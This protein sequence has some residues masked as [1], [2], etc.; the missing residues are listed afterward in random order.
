MKKHFISNLVV[1]ALILSVALTS[2]SKDKNGK[3][4]RI[5]LS[6]AAT[7]LTASSGT[8]SLTKSATESNV[9]YKITDAGAVVEVSYYD[10]DGNLVEQTLTPVIYDIENHDYFAI[11]LPWDPFDG[12]TVVYLVRKSDGA[13]IGVEGVSVGN[14]LGYYNNLGHFAQDEKGNLYFNSTIIK[15]YDK[16]RASKIEISGSSAKITHLTPDNESVFCLYTVSAK[17]DVYYSTPGQNG[18]N[19]ITSNG[20]VHNLNELIGGG[21]FFASWRGL[22]NEIRFFSHDGSLEGSR[23]HTVNIN[24]NGDISIDSKEFYF[25]IRPHLMITYPYRVILINA[26]YTTELLLAEV[27]NQFNFPRPI[28]LDYNFPVTSNGEIIITDVKYTDNHY[29]LLGAEGTWTWKE[30]YRDNREAYNSAYLIKVNSKTDAV[31]ELVAEGIYVIKHFTV[32]STDEV[33]FNA[34]RKSDGVS[35]LGKFTSSG[36]FQLIEETNIDVTEM[37]STR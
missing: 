18:T 31:T 6:N 24:N 29:Y 14:G 27:E 36:Q 7:V 11:E 3:L 23:I 15:G 22:G 2:C 13:T 16:Y 28:N 34:V 1:A 17:G 8:K 19:V 21:L 20:K 35:I 12:N 30:G 9:L 37:I 26:Y 33:T 10:D 4:S 5:D 32:S 25:W